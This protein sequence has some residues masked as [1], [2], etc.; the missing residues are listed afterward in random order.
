MIRNWVYDFEILLKRLN[1]T[2]LQRHH[3]SPTFNLLCSRSRKTSQSRTCILL[4]MDLRSVPKTYTCLSHCTVSPVWPCPRFL[5]TPSPMYLPHSITHSL[6]F[7]MRL[8]FGLA[9]LVLASCVGLLCLYLC[10][11]YNFIPIS[12]I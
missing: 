7:L 2:F 12:S 5:A 9:L 4:W 10:S 11:P 1:L 8:N 3:V 6:N